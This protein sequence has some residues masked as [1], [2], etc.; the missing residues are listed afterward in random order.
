MKPKILC[1]SGSL[2][3]DSSNGRIIKLVAG[4]FATSAE[5]IIYEG[6]GSLPHFSPEID[7]ENPPLPVAQLRGQLQ[8]ADGVFICTPEYAFGVPGSLKNA[9]DWTVSSAEFSNKP[10][11]LITAS[12]SGEK[13]HQALLYTLDAVGA[14]T[15]EKAKLLIPFIRSKFNSQGEI[16]DPET[17]ED[18]KTVMLALLQNI[19]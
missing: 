10:V 4:L 3:P 2:R 16:K 19:T 9:F 6:L 7:T 14:K 8:A 13:A 5:F 18:I 17:I 11:A 1:I 15:D 12:S